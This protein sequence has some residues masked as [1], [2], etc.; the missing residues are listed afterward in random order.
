MAWFIKKICDLIETERVYMCNKVVSCLSLSSPMKTH[1]LDF[2]E[3]CIYKC[4]GGNC[5][6]KEDTTAGVAFGKLLQITEDIEFRILVKG[7]M[8][9]KKH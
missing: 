1:T 6:F 3:H 7:E 2:L 5:I 9:H 8:T 4:K